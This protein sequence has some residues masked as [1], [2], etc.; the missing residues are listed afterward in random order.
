WASLEHMYGSAA[1]MPDTFRDLRSSDVEVRVKAR[2]YL[3]D[4][5]YHQ[6][7]FESASPH[8]IKALI[9]LLLEKDIPERHELLVFIPQTIGLVHAYTEF[10]GEMRRGDLGEAHHEFGMA[11]YRV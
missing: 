5:V 4:A 7:D 9:D 6:G 11:S 1:N 3:W 10:G 8:V 2:Q